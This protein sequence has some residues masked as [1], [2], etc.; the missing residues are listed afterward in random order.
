[1]I[2]E[3]KCDQET[4]K[5]LASRC[6]K[7]CKSIVTNVEGFFGGPMILWNLVWVVLEKFI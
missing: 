3:T 6:W 1:M 4:M 7:L 5:D 2:Q